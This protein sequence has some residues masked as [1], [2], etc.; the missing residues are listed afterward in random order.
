M[1][2]FSR[3]RVLKLGFLILSVL[4]LMVA[5]GHL[6][7]TVL[8]VLAGIMSLTLFQEFKQGKVLS[9]L[10]KAV[11][12]EGVD[13]EEEKVLPMVFGVLKDKPF[14]QLDFRRKVTVAKSML[15]KVMER[16]TSGWS[17]WFPCC[18]MCFWLFRLCSFCLVWES[19]R[20]WSITELGVCRGCISFVLR[21][22]VRRC[23]CWGGKAGGS[24]A[25]TVRC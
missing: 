21:W 22:M 13:L 12:G 6:E 19:R 18:C 9:K 11:Q 8:W 1:A 5:A 7:D 4:V 17:R 10:R 20:G 3:W 2:L 16:K 24:W 25:G 23:L 15:A 14:G